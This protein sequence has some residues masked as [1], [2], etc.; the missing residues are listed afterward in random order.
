VAVV[1]P[2]VTEDLTG[3]V[4]DLERA[5]RER[6]RPVPQRDEAP[7]EVEYR[8]RIL[9][10]GGAIAEV[11]LGWQR[12]PRPRARCRRPSVVVRCIP[13]QRGATAVP[14]TRVHP[15]VVGD[16]GVTQSELV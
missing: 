8:F 1:D 14:T 12:K 3:Y 10:L 4:E 2:P 11:G 9:R 6:R 5:P 16:V 13:R 7:V 15:A